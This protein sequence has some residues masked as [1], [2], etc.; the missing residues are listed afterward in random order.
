MSAY[1]VCVI[2]GGIVG[3]ATASAVAR[4]LPGA[5]IVVVE[6][7]PEVASHQTGHN[8]GVVHS[9][10]YYKPGSLKARLCVSGQ[11][12]ITELCEANGISFNRSGK[13][14]VA[15]KE[16]ELPALET[17]FE[18]GNAN[19]LQ[20]V[21]RLT[22]EELTR[23]EPHVT[24]MAG[25]WVPETAVA[26]FPGVARHLAERL[27]TE[28]TG[29]VRRSSGVLAGQ[30]SDGRTVLAT[31]TGAIDARLVVNCAGLQSDRVARM[32]GIDPPVRIVP[33]RG[34][35][36]ELAG[37]ADHLVR[38]LIYPVPDPR[39]PFL[40]VHF[41]RRHDGSVEVGPNA[42][43]AMGREFYRGARPNLRD[44]S[45]TFSYGG[46][47]H[48]ARRYWKEG[49][50]EMWRSASRHAYA[51]A[52]RALVPDVTAD[53]LRPAGAGVRAQAVAPDGTL[54]DDFSIVETDTALHVLNAPSPAATASLAIGDHLAELVAKRFD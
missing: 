40:G 34:E 38:G 8:S 11:R 30:V 31:E 7:E 13:L 54:L 21:E 41:T 43:L 5:S 29:E 26:D 32:L 24:G 22:A 16:S 42:V 52:A 39:F 35:Y 46:F 3:L 49:A 18:R 47:W 23:Y 28:G 33:F 48:V 51:K 37:H 36:F 9:G 2:G 17:L 14:V 10:L 19:G 1:D 12:R 27:T 4:R 6:K 44:L 53:D 25:L 50:A 20:G 45:A 15:T